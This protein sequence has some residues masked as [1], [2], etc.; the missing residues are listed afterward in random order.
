M[1]TFA[2]ARP[3]RKTFVKALRA[4][5]SVEN[6]A[7][8]ATQ[9][10]RLNAF[11][12]WPALILAVSLLAGGAAKAAPQQP[13]P[14]ADHGGGNDPAVTQE[15][16]AG[17]LAAGRE[18]LHRRNL[19][20]AAEQFVEALQAD[21]QSSEAQYELGLLRFEWGDLDEAM[22]SLHEALRINPLYASAQLLLANALTQLARTEQ[23]YVDE[24]VLAGRRAVTLNPSQAEPHFNLGFLA[25]RAGDFRTAAAEYEK[26]F[27]SRFQIPGS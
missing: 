11:N 3:A 25:V 14:P 19:S 5:F 9:G 10:L 6:A 26:T 15:A 18:F 27:S 4:C 2:G 8:I 16:A 7:L 22:G 13:V 12:T 23:G 21:P 17:H 24:A 20:A 1:A